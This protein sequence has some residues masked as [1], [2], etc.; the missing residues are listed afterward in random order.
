MIRYLKHS[1]IDPE[2][3]NQTVRNSLFSA[4]FAEY[5]LLDL[6]TGDDTW[7]ALVDDDYRAVMPLPT[8]QK[9]VLKYV[10]TPF[11]ILQMGIFSKESLTSDEVE[12]FLQETTR[13]C[14][15]ADLIM[16]V[17]ALPKVHD[18]DIFSHA[19]SLQ[20]SHNE[21]FANYS[22]NTKRNI[23]TAEKMQCR[24]TVQEELIEEVIRLFRQNRG[25]EGNVHYKDRD[26]EILRRV[27]EYL[28][29]HGLLD[30]YGV[31]TPD[32]ALAAGA[33][34]VKDGNR[35]WFWFSGRDNRLS[36]YKPMFYLM[37]AYIRDHA[38]SD[39]ILDCTTN[40]PNMVRF[41]CSFGNTTYSFPFVRRYKNKIWET[42]L[43]KRLSKL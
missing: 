10:Y 23:R 33:L 2:K 13:H 40:N 41:Y 9:G 14:V 22:N 6:L 36:D 39:L 27:S 32:N 3:W 5:E 34:Y 20:Y 31:R 11:F 7:H 26:Y 38:E 35:R 4:V 24:V 43:S 1:E 8:R 30:I 28:L 21:L 16:N 15:F 19:L 42:I 17:K 37:D 25:Q 12:K 29:N 18:Q